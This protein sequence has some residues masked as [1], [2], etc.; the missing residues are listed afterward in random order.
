VLI[1][2]AAHASSPNMAEGAALAMEDALVLA[3]LLT[4]ADHVEERLL[5]FETR[6]QPRVTWVQ[7]Q[8]HRRDQLRELRPWI[9]RL[10]IRRAGG[11]IY[12]SNY[13]PLLASP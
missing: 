10:V 1:G 3:E 12:R 8:T 13:R 2:D 9:R 11:R 6:R 7:Q 5:E 4:D